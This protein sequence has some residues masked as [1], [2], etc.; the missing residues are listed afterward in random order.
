MDARLTTMDARVAAIPKAIFKQSKMVSENNRRAVLTAAKMAVD[1]LAGQGDQKRSVLLLKSTPGHPA[2]T[3]A[4]E[5][6]GVSYPLACRLLYQRLPVD[7]VGSCPS[8]ALTFIGE[9]DDLPVVN[10]S[11]LTLAQSKHL[12]QFYND[13]WLLA[14]SSTKAAYHER[15]RRFL[16]Q[17][18]PFLV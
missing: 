10:L 8:Q 14:G 7:A 3:F 13:P 6:E 4:N 15:L 1:R 17:E 18:S 9:E 11:A 2:G 5:C 16:L 12:A